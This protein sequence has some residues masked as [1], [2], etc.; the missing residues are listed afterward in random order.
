MPLVQKIS[1]PY[2]KLS[3]I[4]V[5]YN[6][7]YFLEQALFSVNKA[8]KNIQAEIFVVDNNSVDGSVEM[9]KERFPDVSLIV[10]KKNTGFSHANNQAIK[11]AKGEY[12]LLLNPD[13]L[14][15]EDTFDKVILFMEDHPDAGGLGV[16][17]IDGSGKY[18][19]ESKRGLPSPNVA[20][21]KVFGLS[22]LFPKSK[23]FGRYHLGFLDKDQ[24]HQV[25]IL[26]GAFM[27]IRKTVIEKIGM[28]DEAFFMY[29][30]DI[31][32]SYRIIL[33][34][35]K[36]YYYP[37]ARIIHYKGE[38]TKKSSISYVFVFYNAMNI[39]AK[40]HFSQK[41]AK[42]FSFLIHIAIYIRASLAIMNR[43]IKKTFLP[44]FDFSQLLGSMFLLKSY[45]ENFKAAE[46]IHY[47][48][49]LVG[50]M[51]PGYIFIWLVSVYFN[52]GYD[53]PVKLLRIVRGIFTGTIL[54]LIIY[55]LLPESFRFSRALILLG[56]A[57]A[58]ISI[59]ST[60][61]LLR[62]FKI[63]EF[64]LYTKSKKRT[65]IAG[66]MEDG[67]R[68]LSLLKLASN[69]IYFIGFVKPSEKKEQH[70]NA[71]YLG[72]LNQ[73]AE[74]VDVYKIDEVIFC[75]KDISAQHIIDNMSRISSRDV[76]YKIAPPESLYIIGSNS[77]DDTGDLYII[78][79]NTISK[80]ANQRNKRM[81]DIVICLLMIIVF[82]IVAFFI[83]NVPRLIKNILIVLYGK[84]SWV[85]YI[86]FSKGP[87][88]EN[89]SKIKLP[90]IK[91][92]IL[93]P[94]DAFKNKD[95]DTNDILKLN[96]LYAKDYKIYNDLN[97]I[98]KGFKYMGRTH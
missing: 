29:G 10:N 30:E 87:F 66:G 61:L 28:L 79:L 35:Y 54:I 26:S 45:W 42:L 59:I 38:S 21:C 56:A 23:I 82:P 31:D 4:I 63:K 15:E 11:L 96:M 84:K 73:L 6:V 60:R 22:A 51:I 33:S 25:D 62:F 32:L 9:L 71:N 52:G 49:K 86:N 50:I 13:T 93:F 70:S 40:K 81:V 47:Q 97:I 72:N 80:S 88:S 34:G 27:L 3:I 91:Q 95:L 2:M 44:V 78:D 46:G 43:F 92:G 53:K 76:E 90:E 8:C 89:H 77:V 98:F 37:E 39:F 58:S 55:A 83:D 19:P 64:A 24:T 65:V 41:N 57:W 68:V 16:K 5:N 94:S 36:N 74:I 18:L 14:V 20:F 7:K 48:D 17:M 69:T 67:N 75:A 1:E 12:I 85:G